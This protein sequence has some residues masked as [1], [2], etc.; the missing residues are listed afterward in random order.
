MFSSQ[1]ADVRRRFLAEFE[2]GLRRPAVVVSAGLVFVALGVAPLL[3]IGRAVLGVPVGCSAA[4]AGTYLALN[5]VLYV[6]FRRGA[7]EHRGYQ[8]LSM[9]E[10]AIFLHGAVVLGAVTGELASAWSVLTMLGFVALGGTSG[11]SDRYQALVVV[12]T[13]LVAFAAY[14]PLGIGL[15]FGALLLHVLGLVGFFLVAV[16][17]ERFLRSQADREVLQAR[18]AALERD[19]E[20]KHIARDLHDSIGSTLALVGTYCTLIEQ[21]ADRPEA[22]RHLCGRLREASR[23]GIDELRGLLEAVTP[24]RPTLGGLVA[25]LE[26]LLKRLPDST[27]ASLR[28]D[29]RTDTVLGDLARTSLIRVFQEAITNALRHGRARQ[30]ETCIT[31]EDER[32]VL[33]VRD[34]GAGFDARATSEGRRI[35]GMR[36]RASELGGQ[37]RLRSAIGHGTELQFEVPRALDQRSSSTPS[38]SPFSTVQ[39]PVTPSTMRPIG[40]VRNRSTST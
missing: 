14:A 10:T 2:A 25:S 36:E 11:L 18:V 24:N 15:A 37:L 3:P 38:Q 9:I 5:A 28:V 21:N 4:W 39:L 33:S 7:S 27:V 17:A 23:D 31:V 12:A 8:V 16:T 34:D 35:V 13:P 26:R 30:I 6:L 40:P 1:L 22:L 19:S 20:R 29:A 32:I